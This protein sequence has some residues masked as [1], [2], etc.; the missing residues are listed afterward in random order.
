MVDFVLMAVHNQVYFQH[1]DAPAF[2]VWMF[3][4]TW[5]SLL[6][7]NGFGVVDCQITKLSARFIEH[8]LLLIKISED[9]I[10]ETP[11]DFDQVLVYGLSVAAA[12][13]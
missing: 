1:D 2:C 7:F 6:R 4:V 3:A 9:L 12:H 13:G 10:Y 8:L 5:I 11:L